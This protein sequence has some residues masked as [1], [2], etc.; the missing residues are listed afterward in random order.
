MNMRKLSLMTL[1]GLA[2]GSAAAATLKYDFESGDLQGWKITRGGFEMIVSDRAVEFY[3]NTPYTKGGKYFL[4]T[5]ENRNHESTDRQTGL[6][7]SPLIRLASPTITL[8]VGGGEHGCDISL[9]DRRTG[10][11]YAT[12]KGRNAQTMYPVTWNVPKAVGREVFFRVTDMGTGG[13]SHLT[14]DDIV[15]EGEVCADDWAQ[16]AKDLGPKVKPE[17]YV[18]VE[19]AV[20][21]LGEK[22]ASYPAAK[23]LAELADLKAKGC[24]PEDFEP[25]VL[26]MLV[27]ENP[28]LNAQEIVFT[29][30]AMWRRDH[31]NTA[32]IFQCGEINAHSYVTQGSLKA[33]DVKTGKTRDIVPEVANRTIRDPEVDYDGTRLVFAMRN[34]RQDDYHIYTVNADGSNLKQLTSAKGVSDIDPMWLPDGDILFGSTREPKYCMCNRHIMANL[35]RMKPDGANIHQIG[36]STLF[37]GHASVLPDGRILYDRWEYVDRN[38]GDAQGLWVCNPDGTRHA[39]YWGNNTTSPGGVVNARSLSNPSKVIAVLGSCHDRP[40]GALGIIDRSKGVDGREP[41]LRTWPASYRDRIHLSDLK[42]YDLRDYINGNEGSVRQDFDSTWGI[43]R[44]YAD[45]FPIDDEHFICVRQT[46]NGDETALVYFDL[47]GNEVMFYREAPGC[48]SPV[49]LRASKRPPVIETKRN[50]EGPNAPGRFYVQNV[51]IGTHMKGVEKGSIKALRIVESPEKRSWT[52]VRGWGGHGEQAAAMNWHSFENKRILGTVPV[53]ADGSAYFEVPANT[54]V[55]F[56]ALDKDGKLV[57]SMRSGAYLQPGELYGCVGCH[58]NRVGDVPKME[59]QPLAMQRAPS[60]LDG[61]YNLQGLEKGTP[62]H[63]YSFQKEVQPVFTRRC[64]ACHDYGK[65]DGKINLSGDRGAYFCSSYVDLWGQGFI[66]CA[67]GGP[68]ETLPAYSWGSHVSALTKVLEGEH[69][70]K[71]GLTP[72]ER[73]RVITWMDINAPYWPCYE[74]AWPDNYGGRM[75]LTRGEFD[76]LQKITG[77]KVAWSAKDR[78]RQ[79]EQLNFERPECSRILAGVKGKPAYAEALAIIQKG[80]E[81]LKTNPRADMDGFVPCAV[82]RQ[83]EE[84]YQRRLAEERAV[85]EAIRAGQK[86][87]D[88]R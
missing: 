44:K 29:K 78:R 43:S 2:V 22:F 63:L 8:K 25:I 12:A 67:G 32:T 7:E 11:V 41:V 23:F 33:L 77:V 46:G 10:E 9:I 55:Y 5:L 72:E 27:K 53:E 45:P 73:M 61:A 84:R 3:S 16:R 20:K 42:T 76:H 17:A 4:T 64:V 19:A 58:E 39:I 28:L 56:Q 70:K 59:G 82:D 51:Y 40:W 71:A 74:V 18:P 57:Q 30:H 48:H 80:K 14:V 65:N 49:L 79:R 81:R 36:K 85:Y 52:H 35:F 83:R 68:A 86:R 1:M 87:Y 13:W 21:E 62:A 15:C 69:G 31:H 50:F 66:R 34:N 75:P 26:R 38:F 37:E 6:V 47:H 88:N 60:K 54:Y 24:A